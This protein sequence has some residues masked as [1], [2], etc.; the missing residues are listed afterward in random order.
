MIKLHWNLWDCCRRRPKGGT[1]ILTT[2]S[3]PYF[4]MLCIHAMEREKI[5]QLVLQGGRNQYPAL[6]RPLEESLTLPYQRRQ[7]RLSSEDKASPPGYSPYIVIWYRNQTKSKD[8]FGSK[9]NTWRESTIYHSQYFIWMKHKIKKCCATKIESSN[10]QTS[11]L[12]LFP[13]EGLSAQ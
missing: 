9:K 1:E 11:L 6:N 3:V 2:P 13:M 10:S 12:Q 7:K 8:L 4:P 5:L